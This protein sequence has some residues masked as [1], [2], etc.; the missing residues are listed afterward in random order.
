MIRPAL[1]VAAIY[2][3]GLPSFVTA[4]DVVAETGS[5]NAD[6]L[7]SAAGGA[8]A[9]AVLVADWQHAGRG[10]FE[11]SW[12]SPPRAGLT[13]SM[14]LRPAR[15]PPERLG[16][17][18]LL[19]GLAL[20]SAVRSLV[21]EPAAVTLKWPNDLLVRDAKAAGVLVEVGDG[22]VVV[23]MGINVSHELA[24]LPGPQATSLALAF[25]HIMIDRS[26]LLAA[27]LREFDARYHRWSAA[28]GDVRAIG[29]DEEYRQACVTIGAGVEVRGVG[30]DF[31]GRAVDV[32]GGGGLLVD[33]EAAVGD[34]GDK[35]ADPSGRTVRRL[36]TAADVAHVRRRERGPGDL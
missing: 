36:V 3:A 33:T 9:G 7:R 32:D 1:D 14:L 20:R 4:I 6:L 28:R 29:L 13:F 17:L 34:R 27:V 15:V 19:T 12:I 8:P 5:T 26:L 25:P 11:R 18:P 24:E 16:W 2:A 35:A 22:A 10:R 23:G 30:G 31:A 21:D